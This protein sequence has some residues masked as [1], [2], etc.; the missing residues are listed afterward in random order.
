MCRIGQCQADA[1]CIAGCVEHLVD[2]GHGG[3]MNSSSRLTWT[4]FCLHTLLDHGKGGYRQVDV[5]AKRV[6]LCDL[7]DF[8]LFKN[9]FSGRH[10][11]LDDVTID[12][13]D[14]RTLG[15]ESSSALHFEDCK[16]L[17]GFRLA[18]LQDSLLQ[19][20]QRLIKLGGGGDLLSVQFGNTSS[21]LFQQVHALPTKL[22]DHGRLRASL[23][24]IQG[25]LLKIGA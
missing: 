8:R 13:T 22:D 11:V 24:D 7:H 6:D 10:N 23:S 5:N 12:G 17:I 14:D 25:C 21:F 18:E 9:I 16:L 2:D 1:E 4:N 3:D 19:L 15:Q 20:A